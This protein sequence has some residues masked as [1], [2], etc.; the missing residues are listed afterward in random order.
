MVA[1]TPVDGREEESV[2]RFVEHFDRLDDPFDETAD[3]VHVT[4]SGIVVGDRGIV[5]LKHKRMG[6]WLQPG[7]HLDPDEAPWDAAVRE[8]Y[9]ET[10][11]D[12]RL[13]GGVDDHGDPAL[14][15]VDVHDG[16]RGHLHLDLRYLLDGGDAD[17]DPPEGESQD[18]AW[19]GWDEAAAVVEAGLAGLLNHVRSNLQ[20]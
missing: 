8:T 11:L 20:S 16:P 6:I 17:P 14:L 12:V 4:G 10:G 13:A 1:R 2:R 19:F 7:G 18:V 15:H 9:E 5:L 3:A